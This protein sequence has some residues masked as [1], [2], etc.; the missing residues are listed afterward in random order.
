MEYVGREHQGEQ[1]GD[2][3]Y[4][5]PSFS[6]LVSSAS[7]F[8]KKLGLRSLFGKRALAAYAVGLFSLYLAKDVE[9]RNPL[10]EQHTVA[11][12]GVRA[13]DHQASFGMP[14]DNPDPICYEH[15]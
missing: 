8:S 3:A 11:Q 7:T 13:H 12:L 9:L 5:C 15:R 2:S 1:R 4:E 14:G 10:S 6:G